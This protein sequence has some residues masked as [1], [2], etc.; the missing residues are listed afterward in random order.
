MK[1][2]AILDEALT[3]MALELR[4]LTDCESCEFRDE[5]DISEDACLTFLRGKFI[6]EAKGYLK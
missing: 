2:K 4:G 6:N 5:C 3:W 1:T